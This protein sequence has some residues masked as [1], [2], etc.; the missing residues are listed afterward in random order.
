MQ[1]VHYALFLPPLLTTN[2]LFLPP[3]VACFCT[4]LLPPLAILALF[5]RVS[6]PLF[7]VVLL[8]LLPALPL[9]SS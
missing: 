3:P 9:P 7:P 1:R 6:P 4:R 8:L 5:F 2:A